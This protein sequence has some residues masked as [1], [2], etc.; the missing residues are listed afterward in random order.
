MRTLDLRD[1]PITVEEL[2]QA[3][4]GDAVFI[5]TTDGQEYILEAAD[6][7]E[8][9]VIQLRQSKRFMQFLGER[10]KEPGR[11]P[12]ADVEKRLKPLSSE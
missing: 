5:V 6:D 3:A 11:I 4:R 1:K 12:I 9:E 7:F 10:R 8:R 2:F